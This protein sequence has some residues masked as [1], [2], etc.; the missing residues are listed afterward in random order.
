[1][2]LKDHSSDTRRRA[3][4]ARATKSLTISVKGVTRWRNM[5]GCTSVFATVDRSPRNYRS[6][7]RSSLP[8]GI[9]RGQRPPA[10]PICLLAASSQ[11]R[12]GT[13]AM[14]TAWAAGRRRG[15]CSEAE[16]ESLCRHV[17]A[18]GH[19]GWCKARKGKRSDRKSNNP[20]LDGLLSQGRPPFSP[21]AMDVGRLGQLPWL[22]I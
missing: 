7:W 21:S 20:A 11:T 13:L 9:C 2:S 6:A 8:A 4:D 16:Q 3:W 5:H 18:G 10:P 12:T 15:K 19:R 22:L 17:L 1:M 14:A